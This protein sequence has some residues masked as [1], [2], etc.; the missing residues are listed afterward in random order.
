MKVITVATHPDRY[1]ESMLDSAKKNNIDITVL[2][3]GEK[4]QGFGWKFTK[5]IEYLEKVNMNELVMFIDAYD[6]IFLDNGKR[7]EEKFLEI[8]KKINFKILIG[9]D[10]IPT[11][12]LHKYAYKRIFSSNPHNINSGVYMGYAKDIYNVLLNIKKNNDLNNMDDQKMFINENNKDNSIFYFDKN[13][14]II[15]NIFGNF[16][17]GKPDFNKYNFHLIQNNNKFKLFNKKNNT[18]PMILHGPG[19][20]NLDDIILKYNY[21]LTKKNNESRIKYM[22]TTIKNYYKY[23]YLEIFILIVFIVLLI[24]YYLNKK[25]LNIKTV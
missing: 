15:L 17:D 11:N 25:K 1:Y 18:Y 19:N 8:K 24:L 21:K 2:G 16:I 12:N 7:I 10:S 6:V 14:E 23:F 13:N 4:W 9:V 5:M 20:A 22:F 3:M